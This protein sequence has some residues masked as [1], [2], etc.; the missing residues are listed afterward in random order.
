MRLRLARICRTGD[1]LAEHAAFRRQRPE[2]FDVVNRGTAVSF[3]LFND[4]Q[5]HHLVIC[6]ISRQADNLGTIDEP[7]HADNTATLKLKKTAPF[8]ALLSV[9]SERN[10][11]KSLAE[12]IEDWADY[13]V[14][15]DANGDAI[16]ATKSAAAVRKITIEANQTADFEDNDF[17]GKRS[18]MESV[19]AKTKDIMPVAFEF[20]CVPF[21]GLKERS[22]KLRLSIITG[23]RPVLVL[24]I[25]QLE[26][27]Q[28]EMANEFRDLLVEKFKDSKVETFIGTFTA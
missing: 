25:I 17:S 7:G 19:E 16:Q 14:G 18:L 9:N 1:V 4:P 27:V 8:S 22:F 20:K 2:F 12:W 26:A 23:D 3:A 13:L 6:L 15:F 11:Q 28:E 5:L 10:S 24:R 21:E